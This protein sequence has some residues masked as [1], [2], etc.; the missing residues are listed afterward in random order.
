VDGTNIEIPQGR[1]ADYCRRWN[2]AEFALFGS[3][4]G[5]AFRP[6]SD[7]DVLVTFGPDAQ[8]GLFDFVRM[9]DELEEILGREV[10]LVSRQGIEASSNYLRRKAILNSAKVI[11]VAGAE[12]PVLG[13]SG[14]TERFTRATI[15]APALE[16]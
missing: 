16:R 5:D 3:V 9:A 7:V 14:G 4:L 13:E 1:I 6:D 8:W 11:H 10:D 12:G 2:I 15:V